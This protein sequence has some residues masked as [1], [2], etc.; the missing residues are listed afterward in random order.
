MLKFTGVSSD[1]RNAHLEY[2]RTCK[3]YG[4]DSSEALAAK[5]EVNRQKTIHIL[6]SI[7]DEGVEFLSNA[8]KR[9]YAARILDVG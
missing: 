9:S 8:E 6:E 5:S 7:L 4:T 1:V 2:S 3:K